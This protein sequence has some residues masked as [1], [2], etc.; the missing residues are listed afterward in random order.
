MG[1]PWNTEMTDLLQLKIDLA[2]LDADIQKM[3]TISKEKISIREAMTKIANEGEA[4][5]EIQHTLADALLCDLLIL[6][7]EEEIVKNYHKIS[8][9]YA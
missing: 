8:K 2:R 3:A 7:G 1:W 9:W 5:P 6:Y 4:D